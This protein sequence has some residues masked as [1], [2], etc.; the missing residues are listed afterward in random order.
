MEIPWKKFYWKNREISV[1]NGF[2]CLNLFKKLE[3]MMQIPR[4]FIEKIEK[5]PSKID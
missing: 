1:K 5:F 4:I 3:K 2:F